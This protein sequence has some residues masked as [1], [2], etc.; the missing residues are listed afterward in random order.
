MRAQ[1][2]TVA[3]LAAQEAEQEECRQTEVIVVQP[4]VAVVLG[5]WAAGLLRL[6]GALAQEVLEVMVMV[7]QQ[8]VAAVVMIVL[9]LAM[10]GQQGPLAGLGQQG[11]LVEPVLLGAVR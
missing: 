4:E 9:A 11:A 5:R 2:P 6:L 10:Q 1:K 3:A 7:R 8:E